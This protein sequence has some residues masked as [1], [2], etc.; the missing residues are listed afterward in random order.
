MEAV[1]Q[2]LRGVKVLPP[3]PQVLPK[4]LDALQHEQTT[5]EELGELISLDAVLTAKLLH[6]C[7]SVY[8][9]GREPVASVPEAIGRVGFQT[10]FAL[11]SAVSGGRAFNPPAS[12]GLD[13]TQLWRHSLTAAFACKFIADDINTDGN[14]LFTAGLLHDIGRVVLAQAKG[15][16]YGKLYTEA[17]RAKANV[18]E[19]EKAAYGFT[20]AEVGA[21]LMET[22]KLPK[23]LVEAVRFHHQPTAAIFGKQ[24]AAAVCLGDAL[25][26]H[27]EHPA[28]TLALANQESQSALELL[29]LDNRHVDLY[30][31][32]M[33][34]NWDF[35]NRLIALR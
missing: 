8:F 31:E 24:L 35:V 6:Y 25:A 27:F 30:D 11:V 7:N 28:E 3:S 10:I 5:L 9:S 17:L 15:A 34:E 26:H 4:V 16:D 14:L 13:G 12:S 33:Q 20:H 29:A 2:L 19:R 23:V 32:Q 22:W 1:Y 21:S 18:A